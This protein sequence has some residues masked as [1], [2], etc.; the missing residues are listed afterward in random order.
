ML[1]T[2]S[3]VSGF[4]KRAKDPPQSF[5]QDAKDRLERKLEAGCGG[6][7]HPQR[8]QQARQSLV[9]VTGATWFS[10]RAGEA[11][12]HAWGLASI[13]ALSSVSGKELCLDWLYPDLADS[14]L[15]AAG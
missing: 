15:A 2:C 10:A 14:K 9:H 8:V 13:E 12:K 4:S 6:S 5:H 1:R 7:R 11:L 3:P